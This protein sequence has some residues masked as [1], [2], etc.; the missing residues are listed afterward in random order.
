MKMYVI[1]VC[2]LSIACT[3]GIA[4][5]RSIE[6]GGFSGISNYLGDLQQVRFESEESHFAV[7]VFLRYTSNEH[8]AWKFHLYKGEISGSDANYDGLVI[9]DRNL[10][11]KSPI[12]ELG[13]QIEYS[14]VH[15]GE[16]ETRLAAPYVFVGLNYFHFNPMAKYDGEWVELQPLGTEGQWLDRRPYSL[17]QW[18]IPMGIGFGLRVGESGQLGFEV[19]FRKTF[20]D[21][22][23]DVSSQYPDLE[24]LELQDPMAAA[25]SFRTPEYYG[26]EQPNPE[27]KPRGNSDSYDYYLFAGITFSTYLFEWKF[28]RE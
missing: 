1:L 7:G 6:I 26:Q 20:T 22:L 18:S 2:W 19:G 12:F 23:D 11:F 25:L 5:N 27:G 14:P 13:G 15:F 8:F 21:Y 10:H 16:R 24:A 9:R 17:Y 3:Q 28:V 4:Q